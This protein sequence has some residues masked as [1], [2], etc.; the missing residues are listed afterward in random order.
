MEEESRDESDDDD[1]DDGYNDEY[2][3]DEDDDDDNYDAPDNLNNALNCPMPAIACSN[4]DVSSSR[5]ISSLKNLRDRG[6]LSGC[7]P[8][9]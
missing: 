3:G 5:A 4:A 2:E 7:G 9:C 1:Y 8:T 6:R